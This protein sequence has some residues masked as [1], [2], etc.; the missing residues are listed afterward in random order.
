MTKPVT[1]SSLLDGI[2]LALGREIVSGRRN[3]VGKSN[4]GKAI[5][6]L[7]G[8]QVL[9]VEDNLLNQELAIEL[10]NSNGIATQLAEN[11]QEA[12]NLLAKY[13]FD[14]VLMD[15]QM[16]VMDGYQAT[17]EIRKNEG[18]KNLPIIAMTANAMAGD[19]EKVLSVG[20][21]DHIAKPIN[22]N[23]MFKTMAKWITPKNSSEGPLI[24]NESVKIDLPEMHG[25][26][27]N[28]GLATTQNHYKLYLKLLKRFKSTYENFRE[29]FKKAQID[30]DT[31][32]ATRYAHTLKS[33]AGNIGAHDVQ[34][35]AQAL[36][37]A[38]QKG[39]NTQ[40]AIDDLNTTLC[41]LLKELDK[42]KHLENNKNS[43]VFDKNKAN[44]LLDQI[45]ELAEDYDTEAT[46]HAE[47]LYEM[48]EGSDGHHSVQDLLAAIENY[49]FELAIE[50]VAHV[51]A[52][53]PKSQ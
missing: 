52:V 32:A 18:F 33:N 11:G 17:K 47:I 1:P 20:M 13:E 19:R 41:S 48:M 14:G 42:I 53:L 21:N 15:C 9:L 4:A 40:S 37:L 45:A 12:L 24:K 5:Q 23:D 27:I 44:N 10:L 49:D 2:L 29:D 38:C 22:V 35:Q 46:E 50:L 25:I 16:P 36:E 30:S 7:Q 8:A 31:Q 28:S 43:Q 6:A 34:S 26:E 51:R 3:Q 39:E